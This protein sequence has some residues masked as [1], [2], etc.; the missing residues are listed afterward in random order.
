MFEQ[1]DR[2][3]VRLYYWL[4]THLRLAGRH[5]NLRE[6]EREAWGVINSARDE[7]AKIAEVEGDLTGRHKPKLTDAQKAALV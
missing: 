7:L 4:L 2:I 5:P 1:W 6:A 3:N